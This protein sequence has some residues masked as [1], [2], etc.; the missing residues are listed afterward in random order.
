MNH[1][2]QPLMTAV[3]KARR[4]QKLSQADA[5]KK[6]GVGQAHWSRIENGTIDVRLS[7]MIDITR[8]LGYELMLIP[9]ELVPAVKA[10]LQSS[11]TQ[12][13]EEDQPAYSLD[14]DDSE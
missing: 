10:I 5:G 7:S 9:K 2:L 14:D 1:K 4:N 13:F 11:L 8:A 12:D 3:A 6:S